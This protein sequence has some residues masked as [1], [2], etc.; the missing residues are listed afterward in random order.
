M[1][2]R[3]YFSRNSIQSTPHPVKWSTSSLHPYAHPIPDSHVPHPQCLSSAEHIRTG[4]AV[5]NAEVV[6][7]SLWLK[8]FLLLF[9]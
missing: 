9:L 6:G 5:F 8:L 4:E 1:C 2:F 7:I 3:I